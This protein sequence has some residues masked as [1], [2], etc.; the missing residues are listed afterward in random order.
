MDA[1]SKF[2]VEAIED[3]GIVTQEAERDEYV[4]TEVISYKDEET[5][6]EI[7]RMP[8]D[9]Y[10]VVRM[11]DYGTKVLGTQNA[12][13]DT[14]GDCKEEIDSARTFRFLH[15]LEAL[16]EHGLIKGGDL[17]NAIVYVDKEPSK[18][19]M[20]KLREALGRKDISIRPNGIID[21]LTLHHPK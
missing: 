13:L 16:L 14:I 10:Q 5:D 18:A 21:N 17:N 3:A 2:F 15:E 11:V 19:T 1:T 7:I 12:S 9:E 8:S 20:E 4:V 6:S